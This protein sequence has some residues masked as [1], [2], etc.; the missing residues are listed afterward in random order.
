MQLSKFGTDIWRKNQIHGTH[1]GISQQSL[2]GLNSPSRIQIWNSEFAGNFDS[3]YFSPTTN[4]L[5]SQRERFFEGGVNQE[6]LE[7]A[8]TRLNAIENGLHVEGG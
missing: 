2:A 1:K 8:H 3:G 7:R 4:L 6:R 5:L